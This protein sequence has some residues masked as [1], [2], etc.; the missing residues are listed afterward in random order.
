[1]ITAFIPLFSFDTIEKFPHV[2][3][4]LRRQLWTKMISSDTLFL[5]EMIRVSLVQAEY[6][7]KGREQGG[8]S[9]LE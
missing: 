7:S 9:A 1:M 3:S 8:I 6:L 4:E 2:C 5:D